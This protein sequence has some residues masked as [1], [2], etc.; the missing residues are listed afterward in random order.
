MCGDRTLTG[1]IMMIM[2]LIVIIII[3]IIIII[4]VITIFFFILIIIN[5]DLSPFA[6][7]SHP[8]LTPK[9]ILAELGGGEKLHVCPLVNAPIA[10]HKH[11]SRRLRWSLATSPFWEAIRTQST[12][13][14]AQPHA[15]NLEVCIGMPG[16]Q[17]C[18]RRVLVSRHIQQ[19]YLRLWR[20]EKKAVLRRGS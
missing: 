8:V 19:S 5:G 18:S 3:I 17:L 6:F 10:L 20:S 9:A 13:A 7:L 4:I 1:L 16:P 15:N 2:I 14:Q 11:R 12:S